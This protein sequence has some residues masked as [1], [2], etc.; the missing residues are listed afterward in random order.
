MLLMWNVCVEFV[1]LRV[2]CGTTYEMEAW[3]GDMEE[4]YIFKGGG[5]WSVWTRIRGFQRRRLQLQAA[6][7][8]FFRMLERWSV[9]NRKKKK[10]RGAEKFECGETAWEGISSREG[11]KRRNMWLS[12]DW[13][14]K[15]AWAQNKKVL[16]R[17]VKESKHPTPRPHPHYTDAARGCDVQLTSGSDEVDTCAGWW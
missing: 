12:C 2:G 17:T 5:D 13:E 6:E 14:M 9:W 10:G 3:D 11:E 8:R 16:R 1:L 4:G 15:W 7:T